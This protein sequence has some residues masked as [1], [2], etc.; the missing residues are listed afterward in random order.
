LLTGVAIRI[1]LPLFAKYALRA[2]PG[3]EDR[4]ITHGP[5]A[6]LDAADELGV[7]A[8]WKVGAANAAGKQHVAHK[9]ALCLRAVKHH[10]AGGVVGALRTSGLRRRFAPFRRRVASVW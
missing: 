10:V 4:V 1:A 8:L 2:V 6:L 7:F 5:K 9:R 3:D